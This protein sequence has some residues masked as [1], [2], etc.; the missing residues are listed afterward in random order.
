M[1]RY[2]C[3]RCGKWFKKLYP[4][5]GFT[6]CKDCV[7]KVEVELLVVCEDDDML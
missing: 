7:E 5:G 6:V 1:K 4:V 3:D 2:R